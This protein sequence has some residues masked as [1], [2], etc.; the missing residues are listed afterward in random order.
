M[1]SAVSV[2]SASGSLPQNLG[3]GAQ[4]YKPT[5]SSADVKLTSKQNADLQKQIATVKKVYCGETPQTKPTAQELES[6]SKYICELV[7]NPGNGDVVETLK[8]MI[9]N[10][11]T[12]NE[13]IAVNTFAMFVAKMNRDSIKMRIIQQKFN[14]GTAL[15]YNECYLIDELPALEGFMDAINANVKDNK[16]INLGK[17]ILDTAEENAFREFQD[18]DVLFYNLDGA[19]EYRGNNLNFWDK[20]ALSATKTALGTPYTHVGVF[21]R[22]MVGKPCVGQIQGKFCKSRLH[23]GQQS[24]I[25]GKRVDPSKLTA[26]KLTEAER[27][28]VQQKV[29]KI[30]AG[31]V[32]NTIW[33]INIGYGQQIGCVFKHTTSAPNTYLGNMNI[34][35]GGE[36]LLCSEF[37]GKGLMQAFHKFNTDQPKVGIAQKQVTLLNPFYVYEDM[38]CLHPERLLVG[39]GPNQGTAEADSGWEDVRPLPQGSFL[40][41]GKIMPVMPD[42]PAASYP[43]K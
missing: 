36:Y 20:I 26:S 33:D 2:G 13:E 42:F 38:A 12:S 29:G 7:E 22:N 8:G 1:S 19:T 18:G 37:A 31:I 39:F 41:L 16:Y 24:Y 28:E 17:A 25:R 32:S 10:D 21:F 3:V 6:L 5:V 14:T 23:F 27:T 4:Y 34:K 35:G 30:Y 43:K 15:T 11:A 40:P 9:K